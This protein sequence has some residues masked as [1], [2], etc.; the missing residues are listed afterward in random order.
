MP[1]SV[2]PWRYGVALFPLAPLASLGSTAGTRLFFGLSLRG[3][4]GE[5]E[6]LAAVLAFLLS[7]VLSWAGVVVAL[8]VIAAL[9][10][11]ARA[12]RRGDAAFSPQPA[13]AAL[14]GFVHLAASA[15]PPLYVF[16]V[17]PLGYYTYRRFA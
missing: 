15:L 7:A 13:L 17:P 5:T 1:S 16:S 4:A 3:H 6:A 14:L 2:P 12:L 8:L 10:L 9:V 11:D